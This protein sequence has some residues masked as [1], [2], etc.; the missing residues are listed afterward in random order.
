MRPFIFAI[1]SFARAVL[2]TARRKGNPPL[3]DS[4]VLVMPAT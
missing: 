4:H 3:Q 2:Q 1:L